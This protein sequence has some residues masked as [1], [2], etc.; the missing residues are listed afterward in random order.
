ME[1]DVTF[2]DPPYTVAVS[3]LA[4]LPYN[5]LPA[6]LPAIAGDSSAQSRIVMTFPQP[7]PDRDLV[8]T[9][10][11]Y[12][13]IDV[14]ILA[15]PDATAAFLQGVQ[16]VIGAGFIPQP[17]FLGPLTE[18]RH[19]TNLPL[20]T[21]DRTPFELV[22]QSAF[23]A[24]VVVVDAGIAFWNRR[25]IDSTGPRFRAIRFLDFDTPAAGPSGATLDF[26]AITALCKRADAGG[27]A[28]RQIV[29]ELL[30]KFPGSFYGSTAADDLDGLWHGTAMADLA[31]GHPGDPDK[32]IALFGL[33]LST[34]MVQDYGGDSLTASLLAVLDAALAMTSGLP[35]KPV[36]ILLPYAFSAGPQDGTHPAAQIIQNFLAFHGRPSLNI[37]VSAGNHLQNRLRAQLPGTPLNGAPLK[38][39]WWEAPDDFSINTVEA[40]IQNVLPM[41]GRASLDIKAPTNEA[42]SSSGLKEGQSRDIRRLGAVIGSIQRFRNIGNTA[43]L[44]LSLMPSGQ[45]GTKVATPHGRWVLSTPST[46][47]ADLWILR[48]DRDPAFDQEYPHRQ[49]QFDHPMYRPANKL[50]EPGLNDDP[51]SPVMRSGTLSPLGTA[52]GVAAVQA[53]EKLGNAA[54]RQAAYSSK[55]DG[56]AVLNLHYL[57][58]DGWAEY[59]VPASANGSEQRVR[60]SGTSSAAALH[61]RNIIGFGGPPTS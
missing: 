30:G 15:K 57:V 23:D 14:D 48:D 28:D 33:E 17:W 6:A 22:N 20:L 56:P 38:L 31:A 16:D 18:L 60:V 45:Y 42:E 21:L 19:D 36:T 61:A 2:S 1:E 47:P 12:T 58:D 10:M 5:Y 29:R 39:D 53:D 26:D 51:G 24:A 43:R 41:N 59:G 4:Y 8:D 34:K 25:F 3:D 40:L 49:S 46:Q 52:P 7:V 44:R 54:Q 11:V 27:D 50:G 37:V 32:R 13:A 9:A 55:P 35:D